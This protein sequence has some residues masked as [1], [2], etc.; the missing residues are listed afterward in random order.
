MRI[1]RAEVILFLRVRTVRA[2]YAHTEEIPMATPRKPANL[3]LD[4]NLKEDAVRV[5]RERYDLSLSE[6]VEKLLVREM[7][8]KKGL[9]KTVRKVVAA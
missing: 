2:P 5:A 6:M 8:L 4:Q 3:Y 7:A 9:L 1:V